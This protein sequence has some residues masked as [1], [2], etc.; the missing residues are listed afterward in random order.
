MNFSICLLFLGLV[1]HGQ[2][3]PANEIELVGG[4]GKAIKSCHYNQLKALVT[5][6]QKFNFIFLEEIKSISNQLKSAIQTGFTPEAEKEIN[7][8][9]L[10]TNNNM[11]L[12]TKDK[13]SDAMKWITDRAIYVNEKD[14]K[15]LNVVLMY[16]NAAREA[17]T[18]TR[19]KFFEGIDRLNLLFKENGSMEVGST[20]NHSNEEVSNIIHVISS[21][22]QSVEARAHIIK[23]AMLLKILN[24][25]TP[26]FFQRMLFFSKCILP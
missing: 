9:L 14:K 4:N 2:A 13:L 1:I 11:Y 24:R 26:G 16:L 10:K 5:A 18:A 22:V 20:S 21:A 23:T 12:T 6:A 3:A 15:E 7:Q 8:I 19:N 25:L 17:L